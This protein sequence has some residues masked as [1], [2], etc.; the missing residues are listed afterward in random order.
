MIKKRALV[1]DDEPDIRELLSMTLEQMGLEVVTAAKLTKARKLLDS[2]HFDLCL[3]DMNMPDGNGL[4][5]V[6]HVQAC[7]PH[8]PIAMISAYGNMAIA[9]EA[10][11]KGAFDFISKP[12]ELISLRNI[13]QSALKLDPNE[14]EKNPSSTSLIGTSSAMESLKQ[15]IRRVAR[16]QAPIFISGESGSGKEL[17]ARAIHVL[18]PRSAGPFIPVNCGAIPSELME[19][20]FFG[21]RKGS[22]TGAH[23]DK[24][25]L[26]QAANG[27]TLLLDEVADLPL[28]M[29]VKL[30]RAI[31]EKS[32]RP[33]GAEDE[34]P[35][36][37]RILSATHKNLENEVQSNQFRQDLFYRINVIELPV[38][39]LRERKDDIPQLAKAFLERF[40]SESGL[41]VPTLS[42]EAL[43]ALLAYSFPGNIRE[44]E[45]T[46]ERAFTLCHGS[47]IGPEDLQLK[48]ATPSIEQLHQGTQSSDQSADEFDSIDDYLATIEKDMLVSALERNRWN[49]TTTAKE[50][51][52][53]FRQMRH[54]LK[55][56]EIE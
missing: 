28:E 26:F 54:K 18:G 11:K 42:D 6:D 43:Q 8:L 39:S 52:I 23:Q 4:E 21:H 37:V 5:L 9:I 10:L 24:Q 3:T 46:L 25:G 50:L 30:L 41:P 36:D 32:V 20:E 45:N 1:V 19:S 14:V 17:V 35:V 44:L 53:S 40:A 15:Q 29:Q 48:T 38:P 34:I 33:V 31:Q 47:A 27:G 2:E 13:V 55:K 16:S 56:F 12:L 51:G 49:K 22:F 7:H